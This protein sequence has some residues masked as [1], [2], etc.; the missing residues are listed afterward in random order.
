VRVTTV[1]VRPLRRKTLEERGID[2][3][4]FQGPGFEFWVGGGLQA[5]GYYPELRETVEVEL[6]WATEWAGEHQQ[7]IEQVLES[8]GYLIGSP[9][10]RE[11]GEEES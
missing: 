7:H 10:P 2:S 8:A 4:G 9:P 1:R 3:S 11:N 5:V 6:E